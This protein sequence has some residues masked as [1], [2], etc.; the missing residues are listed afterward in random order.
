M[1]NCEG[2]ASVV[3]FVREFFWLPVVRPGGICLHG[4]LPCGDATG[5]RR[6]RKVQTKSQIGRK[7]LICRVQSTLHLCTKKEAES[8]VNTVISC[9]EE[10]LLDNLGADGFSLK[11]NSLG[12]FAVRHRPAIRRKIGFSGETR[13]IPPKRKIRFISLGRLRQ[14]ERTAKAP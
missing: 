5:D 6:S 12:K 1:G 14:L 11:L 9:V 4:H 7:E 2:I 10:T 8:I 13:Q 3:R